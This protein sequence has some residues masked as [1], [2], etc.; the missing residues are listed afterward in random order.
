M[1]AKLTTTIQNIDVKVVNQSNRQIIKDFYKY[2]QNTDTSENYQNGL[3]KVLIR[4]AEY[5]GMNATIYQ[6]Q[7]KEQILVFS[8]LKR[9]TYNNE[10]DKKW[11][12]R[13]NDGLWR[14]KYFFRWLH[15]ARNSGRL[16][17][18]DI[19]DEEIYV[20]IQEW[21]TPLFL[22]IDKKNDAYKK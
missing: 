13:W 2:L 9:K 21:K 12:T 8:D 5:I 11:I 22:K 7:K 4:Y 10:T 1:P 17:E 3:L 18:S 20:P 16:S 15:N 19:E 14:L 6:I